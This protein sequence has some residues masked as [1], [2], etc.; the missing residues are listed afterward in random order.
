MRNNFLSQTDKYLIIPDLPEN[1]K[2]LSKKIKE[3]NKEFNYYLYD[4]NDCRNFIKDNFGLNVLIAFDSLKPGA[5]KADLWRYCILFKKGGIY[6]D[7]KYKLT[8]NFKFIDLINKE[9]FV[10]DRTVG[11]YKEQKGIYTGLIIASKNNYI[12]LKLINEIVE[13]VKNNFIG[14]NS[15]HPTGPL[16]VGIIYE[17]YMKK[18]DKKNFEI[19]YSEDG[20][21]IIHKNK[22]ILEIYDEYRDDLEKYSITEH[23]GELWNKKNIYEYKKLNVDKYNKALY[24]YKYIS[25]NNIHYINLFENNKTYDNIIINNINHYKI[26]NNDLINKSDFNE[27]KNNFIELQKLF[28][29]NKLITT[30]IGCVES[31][32]ILKYIFNTLVEEDHL[33]YDDN[34]IDIYMKTNAGLYYK[35]EIDKNKVLDWWCNNTIEII[36]KSTLTSCYAFLQN[37]LL[38]WSKLNLKQEYYNWGNIHEF[39]LKNLKDKKLLYI[40][41]AVKS[42]KFAYE[43]NVQNAWKFHIPNFDM[44]FLETPQTTLKMDYPHESIIETTNILVEEIINKYSDFDVAILGCGAYGPPIINILSQKFNNKN[45]LYLG[46]KCFTMF[47]I[48]SNGIEISNS[49]KEI[50]ENWITVL[51]ECDER[52]KNIDQGKYWKEIN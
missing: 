50:K 32:F 15:L 12:F 16:L 33:I 25:T 27:N 8:N 26:S 7:I 6:L 18:I 19:T 13:N 52:C 36:K 34:N 28:D 35:N 41:N 39:L 43:R 42:I 37:D 45:M 47:G 51:E 24:I 46:S 2:I 30:R 44:Y 38:L 9:Y 20:K 49:G 1:M 22:I 17:K 5:Y 3:N 10:L 11:Y 23:Y 4:D 31:S 29:E 14:L 40:G 21:H 48:Y